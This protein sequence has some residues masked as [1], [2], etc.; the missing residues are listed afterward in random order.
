M[1]TNTTVV[2]PAYNE[3]NRISKVIEEVIDYVDEVLVVDDGSSDQTRKVASEAGAKVLTHDKNKGYLEAL[4]TG[5]QNSEA[6]FIVTIDAD[7]EMNPEYIPELLKPLEEDE[8]DL[9]LGKREK[10]PRLSER[11]LSFLAGLKAGV[12][13]TGTGFRAVK[14]SLAKKMDLFG[15]CPCGTFVL[16]AKK[17]GGEIREVSVRT[18]RV[19]KPRQVAWKHFLQ[20]WHILKML[21]TF[22]ST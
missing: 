3:E 14:T 11:F 13:D 12:S 2:I 20:F 9:V 19:E 17:L 18:R 22:S 8:A 10:I 4:K 6:D 15:V 16:E 7:G 1:R 21:V 5:F